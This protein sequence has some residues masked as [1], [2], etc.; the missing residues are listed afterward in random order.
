MGVEHTLD[1]T[2]EPERRFAGASLHLPAEKVK[3]CSAWEKGQRIP[4]DD[5]RSDVGEQ[6]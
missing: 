2:S 4:T 3:P 5:D 6:M 1:D